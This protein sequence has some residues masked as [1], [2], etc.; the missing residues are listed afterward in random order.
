MLHQS[1][2]EM[3]VNGAT[4]RRERW[5]PI[6][7]SWATWAGVTTEPFRLRTPAG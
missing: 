4:V 1:R 3:T 7:L 5:Q 6:V 2:V